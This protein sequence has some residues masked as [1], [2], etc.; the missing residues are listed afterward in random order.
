MD[1]SFLSPWALSCVMPGDVTE[2]GRRL[3]YR[4]N[5]TIHAVGSTTLQWVAACVDWGG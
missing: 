4:F 5:R 3:L 1:T 2:K